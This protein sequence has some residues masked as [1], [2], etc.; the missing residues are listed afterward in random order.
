MG[1]GFAGSPVDGFAA[2]DGLEA[3][4]ESARA[5]VGGGAVVA[6]AEGGAGS[7]M[8]LLAPE[9]AEEA[10]AGSAALD[11]A[12]GRGGGPGGV[13]LVS[14]AGAGLFSAEEAL[15]AAADFP[16]RDKSGVLSRFVF[17]S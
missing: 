7:G 12:G 4:G 1:V 14:A 5:S 6:S 2:S 11:A 16:T 8:G 10:A 15:G 9:S 3:A 17:G 13:G